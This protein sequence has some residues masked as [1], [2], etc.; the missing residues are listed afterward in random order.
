MCG[1]TGGIW[2]TPD[3][4]IDAPLLTRMTDVLR[5]RGPDDDGA[6][7]N[8]CQL[9]DPVAAVPSQERCS[10]IQGES[11][12]SAPSLTRRAMLRLIPSA[13]QVGLLLVCA[14]MGMPSASGSA[15]KGM[16]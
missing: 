12:E 16:G 1:I 2:S 4:A 6:Y 13:L 14:R 15:P 3:K 5:H 7:V 8:E 10:P 9:Q 11:A